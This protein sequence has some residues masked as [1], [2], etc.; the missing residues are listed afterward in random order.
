MSKSKWFS[1][2]LAIEFMTLTI[3]KLEFSFIFLEVIIYLRE[4]SQ[5]FCGKNT[6]FVNLGLFGCFETFTNFYTRPWIIHINV[7]ECY[8]MSILS[9]KLWSHIKMVW[10]G[11]SKHMDNIEGEIVKHLYYCQ[12]KIQR[13][14]RTLKAILMHQPLWLV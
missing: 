9:S 3:L 10:V 14:A 2:V 12:K 8:E 6:I 4:L 5:T 1:V 7:G 13:M 11:Q